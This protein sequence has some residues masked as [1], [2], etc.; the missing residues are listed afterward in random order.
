MAGVIRV[1]ERFLQGIENRLGGA[2]AGR[3]QGKQHLVDI[4]EL[5]EQRQPLLGV[6]TFV[7]CEQLELYAFA[8][9]QDTPSGVDL[10]HGQ[11]AQIERAFTCQ[12]DATGGRPHTTDSQCIFRLE[13]AYWRYEHAEVARYCR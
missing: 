3:T 6:A 5:R 7:I 13:S 12:G 10:L 4:L 11:P 9:N 1:V 8:A 2:R